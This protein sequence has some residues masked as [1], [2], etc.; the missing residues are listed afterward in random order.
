MLSS[1]LHVQP[2]YILFLQYICN[3]NS[4]M[5]KCSANIHTCIHTYIHTYMYTHACLCSVHVWCPM[6]NRSVSDPLEVEL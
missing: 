3:F 1:D 6:E 2:L 4:A 5:G